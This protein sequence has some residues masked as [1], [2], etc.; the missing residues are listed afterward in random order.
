MRPSTADGFGSRARR[1]F[2]VAH[3]RAEPGPGRYN[4]WSSQHHASP[5]D[6]LSRSAGVGSPPAGVSRGGLGRLPIAGLASDAQR[7]VH[8]RDHTSRGLQGRAIV[9]AHEPTDVARLAKDLNTL[10]ARALGGRSP[11]GVEDDA[12]VLARAGPTDAERRR[13]FDE[14]ARVMGEP[15]AEPLAHHRAPYGAP[16][17]RPGS[18]SAIAELARRGEPRASSAS[19]GS[20]H[21]EPPPAGRPPLYDEDLAYEQ[22]RRDALRSASAGNT[23]A[24]VAGAGARR[25]IPDERERRAHHYEWGSPAPHE[26]LR[27]AVDAWVRAA[28]P[29]RA[30]ER[31]AA[32]ADG[33]ATWHSLRPLMR[34]LSRSAWLRS[35]LGSADGAAH[36]ARDDP[37]I[38]ARGASLAE[39]E[40]RLWLPADEPHAG[41]LRAP[42]APTAAHISARHVDALE[43]SLRALLETMQ[44]SAGSR[45]KAM[46]RLFADFPLGASALHDG[47]I[48]ADDFA[49]ML[50]ATRVQWANAQTARALF[51]RY[52]FDGSRTLTA[53]ELEA[54]LFREGR[55]ARARAT[56]GRVREALAERGASGAESMQDS[57]RQFRIFDRDGSGSVDRAEFARGLQLCLG[58]TSIWPLSRGD[59]ECLFTTFDRDGDGHVAFE[60]FALSVR[61]PLPDARLDVVLRAYDKLC[62]VARADP[63]EGV[64]LGEIARQYDAARHPRVAQRRA[65]EGQVLAAYL[66]GFDKDNNEVVTLGEFVEYY[67]WLGWSIGDDRLFEQMIVES[68]H[69]DSHR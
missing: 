68:L 53:P 49:R 56:I 21:A 65:T 60:E 58:G 69:L 18:A 61:S 39:I 17:A 48:G 4:V 41:E 54:M 31:A 42:A 13:A 23:A 30:R 20:F 15:E 52:D 12:G 26:Q 8:H 22:G 32:D 6:A 34:Q 64:R 16:D 45:S 1:E 47:G 62:A 35:K 37:P 67:T 59:L 9:T 36:G 57:V 27:P 11:I 25:A 19:Y 44:V 51:E 3:R 24:T 5:L 14:Y 38:S 46:R 28:S 10:G 40:L 29:P 50:V 43:A 55:G 7:A 2:A 33:G 66:A 63:R